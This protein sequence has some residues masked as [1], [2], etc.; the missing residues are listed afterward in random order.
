MTKQYTSQGGKKL[1][2]T[3]PTQSRAHHYCDLLLPYP[4]VFLP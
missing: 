4:N 3:L 2:R 1:E